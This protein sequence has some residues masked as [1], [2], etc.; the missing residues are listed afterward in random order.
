[1]AGR[2]LKGSCRC[3]LGP[4]FHAWE[5]P[6]AGLCK[7]AVYQGVGK[8]ACVVWCSFRHGMEPSRA[9]GAVG[10]AAS[11]GTTPMLFLGQAGRPVPLAHVCR[12]TRWH[13]VWGISVIGDKGGGSLLSL[14]LR[15]ER[16][17]PGA[18]RASSWKL[19]PSG[20]GPPTAQAVR[21]ACVCRTWHVLGHGGALA[22][23]AGS[24]SAR[25]NTG[26]LM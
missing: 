26:A 18:D 19:W 9:Q 6:S 4:L 17:P 12:G 14:W 5:S 11:R 24:L 16:Q 20:A 1:M 23:S 22:T 7:G 10:G 13:A 8:P 25:C 15:G 3:S 2:T 21:L